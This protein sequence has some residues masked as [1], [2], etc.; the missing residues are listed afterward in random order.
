MR[1]LIETDTASRD[2][3]FTEWELRPSRTGVALQLQIIGTA[4]RKL[5]VDLISKEGELYDLVQDP[6]EMKNVFTDPA[7]ITIVMNMETILEKRSDD[8][9]PQP[10]EKTDMA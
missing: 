9:L 1:P 7:H 3:A 2:H 5:T 4:T 6:H 10:M 8:I